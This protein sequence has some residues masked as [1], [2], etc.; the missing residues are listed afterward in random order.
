MVRSKACDQGERPTR[1]AELLTTVR[2]ESHEI[3]AI[4]RVGNMQSLLPVCPTSW[5]RLEGPI[6]VYRQKYGD[7]WRMTHRMVHKIQKIKVAVTYVPYQD[8]ENKS[9]LM[10][11][12]DMDRVVGQADYLPLMTLRTCPSFAAA[13][14][15]ACG[16]CPRS[17]RVCRT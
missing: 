10:W 2:F 17:Y 16:G 11:L 3:P 6:S 15:G 1:N 12:E 13:S 4:F 14:R 9:M 7:E 5:S 8:F